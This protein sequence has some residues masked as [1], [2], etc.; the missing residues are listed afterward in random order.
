[1]TLSVFAI[2]HSGFNFVPVSTQSRCAM[3]TLSPIGTASFMT[4]VV[5][6]VALLA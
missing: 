3:W 6:G 1:V 2:A 4:L 5:V